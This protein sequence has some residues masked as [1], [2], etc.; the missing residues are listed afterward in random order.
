MTPRGAEEPF[1]TAISDEDVLTRFP[2]ENID[3]DNKHYYKGLL[4]RRLLIN[5]CRQCATW[6]QPPR[7]ICPACWSTDIEP[8]E[9][10]G[11]GVIHLLI[12][13]HQGPPA[14]GVDYAT[15]H[16]VAVIELAEQEGL[17]FTTTVVNADIGDLH[18]GMPV[19]LTWIDRGGSPFPAFEPASV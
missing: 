8:V 19:T 14:P 16:P 17:R 5:R 3:H 4:E 18:I 13:L 2:R 11:K 10:S 6:R 12:F 1:V 7:P 15:P 9:V